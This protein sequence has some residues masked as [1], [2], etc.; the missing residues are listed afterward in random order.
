MHIAV[1]CC[2]IPSHHI[3]CQSEKSIYAVAEGSCR[4]ESYKGIH[5]RCKM[6]QTLKSAYKKLLIYHHYYAGKQHLQNA[7]GRRVMLKSRRAGPSP[8]HY[9][10]A[11]I[12]E[13]SKETHR[14]CK[15]SLKHR[16]FT[17]LQHIII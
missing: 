16:S 10:H 15:P 12:H 13:Y 17:V 1:G 7:H 4:T 2:H 5:V 11:E 9:T 3:T 6:P 8:H 14:R